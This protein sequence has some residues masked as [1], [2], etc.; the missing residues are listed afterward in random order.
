MSKKTKFPRKFRQKLEKI[1]AARDARDVNRMT[2]EEIGREVFDMLWRD[3]LPPN[4]VELMRAQFHENRRRLEISHE[5]KLPSFGHV[6]VTTPA[7][8]LDDET[9]TPRSE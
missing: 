2:D 9:G 7:P 6:M 5:L 8:W 4:S 3:F 1:A